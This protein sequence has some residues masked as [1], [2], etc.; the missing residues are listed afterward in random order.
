[1]LFHVKYWVLMGFPFKLTSS[2]ERGGNSFFEFQE[3]KA[4]N[5]VDLKKRVYSSRPLGEGG[6]Q[7]KSLSIPFNQKVAFL[8]ALGTLATTVLPYGGF[9]SALGNIGMGLQIVSSFSLI[10]NCFQNP[11]VQAAI[12]LVSLGLTY[13]P[14][15]PL[16]Q[17]VSTFN[18]CVDS[19]NQAKHSLSQRNGTN[20]WLVGRNLFVYSVNAFHACYNLWG[21]V[22]DRIDSNAEVKEEIDEVQ[23]AKAL[24]CKNDQPELW[25]KAT[26]KRCYREQAKK[27]HPDKKGETPEFIALREAHDLLIDRIKKGLPIVFEEGEAYYDPSAESKLQEEEVNKS[28]SDIDERFEGSASSEPAS[29]EVSQRMLDICK[30]CLFPVETQKGQNRWILNRTIENV[31]SY[32]NAQKSLAKGPSEYKID[33]D[34]LKKAKELLSQ[35]GRVNEWDK[36][37]IEKQYRALSKKTHPDKSKSSDEF[38]KLV[39]AR[40]LL[41][42]E[43]KNPSKTVAQEEVDHLEKLIHTEDMKKF[44]YLSGVGASGIDRKTLAGVTSVAAAHVLGDSFIGG[45]E[46]EGWNSREATKA[47]DIF[48]QNLPEELRQ[49]ITDLVSKV[50]FTPIDPNFD[51]DEQASLVAKKVKFLGEGENLYL[52]GGWEVKNSYGHA[53]LYEFFKRND[54]K[55]DIYVYNTGAGTQFHYQEKGESSSLVI[56]PEISHTHSPE[57]EYICPF[58]KFEAVHADE[59]GIGGDREIDTSLFKKLI[60]QKLDSGKDQDRKLYVDTLGYLDHRRVEDPKV[61]RDFF[62]TLPQRAGTCSWSVYMYAA[63]RR[64]LSALEHKA[65][66]Y[67]LQKDTFDSYCSLQNSPFEAVQHE[68]CLRSAEKLLRQLV[69][70]HEKLLTDRETQNEYDSIRPILSFLSANSD[71]FP[72]IT[73]VDFS[74][75]SYKVEEGSRIHS[76]VETTSISEELKRQKFPVLFKQSLQL[77]HLPALNVELQRILDFQEVGEQTLDISLQIESLAK[78]LPSPS[79][80]KKAWAH[81]SE[82]ELMESQKLLSEVLKMYSKRLWGKDSLVLKEQ[83]THWVFLATIHQICTRLTPELKHYAL[84]YDSLQALIKDSHFTV[85][86][87]DELK[88]YQE[89][90][91]YFKSWTEDAKHIDLFN[92]LSSSLIGLKSDSSQLSEE[93]FLSTLVNSDESIR[94]A[95]SKKVKEYVLSERYAGIPEDVIKRAILISETSLFENHRKLSHIHDLREAV[96]LAQSSIHRAY[97]TSRY[98]PYSYSRSSSNQAIQIRFMGKLLSRNIKSIPFFK[99]GFEEL[100]YLYTT[101]E[102]KGIFSKH[103]KRPFNDNQR[104][105]DAEWN[106]ISLPIRLFSALSQKTLQSYKLLHYFEEHIEELSNLTQQNFLLLALFQASDLDGNGASASIHEAI[107]NPE[108]LQILSSFIS[109][110]LVTFSESQKRPQIESSLFFVQIVRRL[111]DLD[112]TLDLPDFTPQ[113]NKWLALKDL[114]KEEE[115]LLHLHRILQYK[116]QVES[117]NSLTKEQ[118][119]KSQNLQDLVLSWMY[120]SK[121]S[122]NQWHQFHSDKEARSLIFSLTPFLEKLPSAFLNRLFKIIYPVEMNLS[123]KGGR[124][125]NPE[126]PTSY[127]SFETG[128]EASLDP[129]HGKAYLNGKEVSIGIQN[130]LTEKS[131]Y[132]VLFGDEKFEMVKEGAAFVFQAKGKTWRMFESLDMR[133]RKFHL[134]F[135]HGGIWYQHVSTERLL[136]YA[137]TVSISQIADHF[138][139]FSTSSP[140]TIFLD[141]NTFDIDYQYDE[142]F[143]DKGGHQIING[144]DERFFSALKEFEDS[145]WFITRRLQRDTYSLE[146]PR[147]SSLLGQSLVFSTKPEGVVWDANPKFF[148]KKP[149]TGILG[150]CTNYL[151][152]QDSSAERSKILVPLKRRERQERNLEPHCTLDIYDQFREMEY[153]QKRRRILSSH[154]EL[155]LDKE[156]EKL[157]GELASPQKGVYR[158]LEYDVQSDGVST[159]NLEG[160]LYLVYLYLSQKDYSTAVKI[161]KED[162]NFKEMAHLSQESIDII[163]WITQ[164][165]DQ[166]ASAAAIALR[167]FFLDHAKSQINSK[168]PPEE[169][170]NLWKRYFNGLN[171]VQG[172][173][174]FSKEEMDRFKP[175]KKQ[176]IEQGNS[177]SLF[178]PRKYFEEYS[179][180]TDKECLTDK[181]EYE[182]CNLHT[183]REFYNAFISA[184]PEYK[185]FLQFKFHEFLSSRAGTTFEKPLMGILGQSKKFTPLP[186]GK[187]SREEAYDWLEQFNEFRRF[188]HNR[189]SN[190]YHSPQGD[191]EIESKDGIDKLETKSLAEALHQVRSPSLSSFQLD[192]IILKNPT[193]LPYLFREFFQRGDKNQ[194]FLEPTTL[195]LQEKKGRYESAQKK[196]FND[197]SLDLRKGQEKNRRESSYELRNGVTIDEVKQNLERHLDLLRLQTQRIK[198]DILYRVNKVPESDKKENLTRLLVRGRV[199]ERVDLDQVL[200]SFLEGSSRG[201]LQLNSHLTKEDVLEID[202]LALKYLKLSV[203]SNQIERAYLAKESNAI[204]EIL[205]VK[206]AY[207]E[208][209]YR[210]LSRLLLIFE[211]RTGMK[212]R[213]NQVESIAKMLQKTKR[214]SYKNVVTQLIMGGGKT[215]V[216]ASNLL[217]LASLPG[218]IAF[219]IPPSEQF[220]TLKEN[221]GNMQMKNFKQKVIPIRFKREELNLAALNWIKD[222]LLRAKLGREMILTT[223]ETVESFELELLSLFENME[224]SKENDLIKIEILTHIL[225]EMKQF[226]DVLG[227]E[228]DILLNP[229]RETNFPSGEKVLLSPELIDMTKEIFLLLISPEFRQKLFLEKNMQASFSESYLKEVLEEAVGSFFDIYNKDVHLDSSQKQAYIDFILHQGKYPGR[230]ESKENLA[231]QK[232]LFKD[233]LPLTLSKS[234]GQNYGR[235]VQGGRSSLV[236][237]YNGVDNPTFTEFGSPWEAMCYHFQTVLFK[238]V[239][240]SQVEE[241]AKSLVP[242]ASESAKINKGFFEETEENKI[243]KSLTGVSLL[244]ID[245][246]DCLQKA[247]DKVNEKPQAQLMLE[248]TSVSNIVGSYVKYFRSTP[249][250]FVDLFSSFRAF[251][252][253]PWNAPSYSESLQ[254]NIYLDHGTEGKIIDTYLQRAR[255]ETLHT[256]SSPSPATT[257]ETVFRNMENSRQDRLRGFI[258]VAGLFKE[259]NNHHIAKEIAAFCA[260][261]HPT[262]TTVLYFGRPKEGMPM[263]LMALK[264]GLNSP[265]VIGSTQREE[266]EKHGIS[267]ESTFV[268]Y[269]ESHCEATDIVQ[270]EDAINIITVDH[271]IIRRSFLQGMLRLRGYFKGQDLEYVLPQNELGHFSG[272]KDQIPT[273]A[274]LLEKTVINQAMRISEET[275]RSYKQKIDNA[276]RK[277]VI[278][279]LLEASNE[280]EQRE[281]FSQHKSLLLVTQ[282]TDLFAQFGEVEAIVPSMDSLEKYRKEKEDQLKKITSNEEV[283]HKAKNSLDTIL[284]SARESLYLPSHTQSAVQELGKEREISVEVQVEQ[285]INVEQ[286]L[287]QDLRRELEEYQNGILSYE[288][289]SEI[290]WKKEYLREGNSLNPQYIT[291]GSYINS[292]KDK[293]RAPEIYMLSSLLGASHWNGWEYQDSYY[294]LFTGDLWVS[295]NFAFTTE[296]NSPVF[297]KLQKN[298]E[299]ILFVRK[300]DGIKAILISSLEAE[301]FKDYIEESLPEDM[302]L[303]LPN[304][305]S[306]VKS[307]SKMSEPE[308]ESVK[309]LLWQV[310][311]FNGNVEALIQDKK[312]PERVKAVDATLLKRFLK[313]KI[314]SQPA[315][316][317]LYYNHFENDSKKKK[318]SITDFLFHTKST[319]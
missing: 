26:I 250:S 245:D 85:F 22:K 35:G 308:Q 272:T 275:L 262:I 91:D 63:L 241:L 172:D 213:E 106:D 80:L 124:D 166:S 182:D 223:R 93:Y 17:L 247:V 191:I 43:L 170:L 102:E 184:S 53:M 36:E 135:L 114:S 302:W 96:Y 210:D 179:S 244:E 235:V 136:D 95:M 45:T 194:T 197:L 98:S 154:E 206:T 183:F 27:L 186:L 164:I 125:F 8:G 32:E 319:S 281:I 142:V 127:E 251:S 138:A 254:G 2:N 75:L 33:S 101:N 39:Q 112:P 110:G 249:Q 79:T 7:K 117:I 44:S 41:L 153:E 68:I 115:R 288:I 315:Q 1:M 293:N 218:R 304:G 287:S 284:K 130:D 21:N 295:P 264:K 47:L 120:C 61:K 289:F 87:K 236:G 67:R 146:L 108:F 34:E 50:V 187:M 113:I 192:P 82:A 69:K 171:N 299:Q 283:L 119:E 240:K 222:Q 260:E 118:I 286:E 104:L 238:G 290:P 226:G 149:P 74:S 162:L 57:K 88:L 225:R 51:I 291:L 248:A 56:D 234:S 89:I 86:D 90:V 201:Y 205:S 84:Q 316:K 128:V 185:T 100:E 239:S 178:P 167:V 243:F 277:V 140:K 214:G 280:R 23:K 190:Y 148:L 126:F 208:D 55:Y 163:S 216:L 270:N 268:Y 168:E 62:L 199:K 193:P 267:A 139:F 174:R 230:E 111:K 58:I 150:T 269:D 160:A 76:I 144:Q 274:Q 220:S 307:P 265:I 253:T 306:Y 312:T 165:D 4:L 175:V 64:K 37:T 14:L 29:K 297:S 18:M 212:V 313:L 259:T 278:D 137:K 217:Y 309:R 12:P 296:S 134:E 310:N 303:M 116:T 151:F 314:E 15:K 252:G 176:E 121:E 13:T 71:R 141:S 72:E 181:S 30:P 156:K 99:E 24:L 256:T 196:E 31:Q 215:S 246:P 255:P 294:K 282:T 161:L 40:D 143:M 131:E 258:D 202:S 227:D 42:S 298:A 311:L 285:E 83:I 159:L 48:S 279:C 28:E 145:R 103:Q 271:K 158:F 59:L 155:S 123:F 257:I 70:F 122:Y 242:S 78:S 157:L 173:L 305:R 54:G 273:H 5:S 19:Y 203:D 109:K 300:S 224:N 16:V 94:N 276:V 105:V 10:Q 107:K 77:E 169:I 147:F 20:D 188:S 198:E 204:G 263:T 211:Y 129:L 318:N 180:L 233:I 97:S 38:Y 25:N 219:F 92:V 133:R 195:T 6:A 65:L 66:E 228:V 237:P 292:P 49:E 52:E 73:S 11:S 317:A 209:E 229:L 177:K 46:V 60:P 189:Q 81:A 301:F 207:T 132:K 3:K 232:H 9:S 231:L 200:A 152:L 261:N 266:I 221:L